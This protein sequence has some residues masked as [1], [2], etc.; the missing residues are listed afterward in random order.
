MHEIHS[1]KDS[2]SKAN[3]NLNAKSVIGD[4]SGKTSIFV[5]N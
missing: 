5:P 4:G 3:L 1:K 2:P